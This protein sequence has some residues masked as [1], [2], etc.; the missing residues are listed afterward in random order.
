[1]NISILTVFEQLYDSFVQTSLIKRAQEKGIV[2]IDV[3]SLFTYVVPKE[4]IDGPVFGPGSGMLIRP[5]VVERAVTDRELK[6]GKAFKIFF[7]PQGQKID[8]NV[9]KTLAAKMQEYGHLMILPARY[10]GMDARV[11]DEYADMLLSCGDF[12][13]MGGDI[14]AMMLLEGVL[15]LFPDV[16]GKQES[17]QRDS[18]TG[19]FVDFP[20]YTE[21]VEWKG[22]RVPD[23]IRSGN[24]G[25]IEKWRKQQSIQK[26]VLNHFTWLRHSVLNSAE[27]AD[28]LP[29]IP[30]HYVALMHS[31][32]LV[33]ESKIDG[34][35]SV[36]SIDIHDIARSSKTYG[37]KQF[38]IVTPLVDQQKIV[39]KM[40]DFWK[41]GIGFDYNRC[42][43]NAIQIVS[44]IDSLSQ[45]IERIKTIEGKEPLILVT[46]A[47]PTY[48]EREISF[49]DQDKVF[50]HDRPLLIL[51]GTGQG[52][53]PSVID[54][55]DFV[56]LPIQGF[57]EFNH[58]S[59]RSA[60]AIA[61]DR[62]LGI[63][64]KVVEKL[65]E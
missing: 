48:S 29:Y 11:E 43:Y 3:Q 23:I 7:S 2:H 45:V 60:V 50:A 36:T 32:V 17:V 64:Q 41:E 37:I 26:T 31:D 6:K 55:A 15:R 5:D 20:S 47:R 1:M 39:S 22:V 40:L 59:V 63:Q 56:L 8:Q 54:R 62:W 52:L 51:F 42:R 14:P 10:E 57:S 44:L 53:A 4:R 61:L 30:S 18:F 9:L 24:H 12:V 38:F 34:F 49:F 16:V 58:L 21:P 19:P 25:A 46:S 28:V 27:K 13:L 33:G 35:T 65:A